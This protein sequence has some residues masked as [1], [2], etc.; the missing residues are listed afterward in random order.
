MKKLIF[1]LGIITILFSFVG[2]S[3]DREKEVERLRKE[4]TD[5]IIDGV[6]EMKMDGLISEEQQDEIMDQFRK[7]RVDS[8]E[9]GYEFAIHIKKLAFDEFYREE[10]LKSSQQETDKV[11]NDN[12]ND[13]QSKNIQNSEKAI[14]ASIK[15]FAEREYPNDMQMQT[16]TYNEQLKAYKYMVT[17]KDLEV[18][19]FAER[20]YPNDYSMQKYTYDNQVSAKRYMQ[21]VQDEEINT[22]AE[23]EYPYDYTMQKYTYDEQLSAKRYMQA[24]TNS[25]AKTKAI[26]EYPYDYSMQK[27]TYDNIAH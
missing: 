25:S 6:V 5:I 11:N 9:L 16:Y 23:R 26:K 13:K 2:C 21:G 15:E 19:K 12:S 14:L 27:Y 20:E 8:A 4:S 17:A 10:F 7:I 24:I 18:L 3:S 22:F 1:N